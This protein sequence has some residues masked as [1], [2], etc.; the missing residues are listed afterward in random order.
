MIKLRRAIGAQHSVEVFLACVNAVT[1]KL[2][3]VV[4]YELLTSRIVA[5][6]ASLVHC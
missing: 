2:L 5:L 6:L 4:L 3:F 1:R